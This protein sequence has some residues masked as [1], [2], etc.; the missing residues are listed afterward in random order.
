MNINWKFVWIA[1][2]VV[3]IY[4]SCISADPGLFFVNNCDNPIR[5]AVRFYEPVNGW[6]NAGF[7]GVN[8]CS[9]VFLNGVHPTDENFYYYAET[10]DGTFSWEGQVGSPGD[11]SQRIQGRNL[12]MRY[13]TLE[14]DEDG[15]Y[16]YWIKCGEDKCPN[17]TQYDTYTENCGKGCG[18][19]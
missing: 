3:A 13:R 10:T 6:Q 11:T 15:N 16:E 19:E 17:Y 7:F 4:P 2:F 18:G 12:L 9:G 8:P 5:V 1:F 14:I